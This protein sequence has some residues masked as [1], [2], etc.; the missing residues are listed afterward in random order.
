MYIPIYMLSYA[1]GNNESLLPHWKKIFSFR[2]T[3]FF[4]PRTAEADIVV[5]YFTSRAL[6]LLFYII[7]RP[8][9]SITTSKQDTKRAPNFHYAFT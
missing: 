5:F 4:G 6:R 3:Y 8:I 9:A 2:S 1:L 7:K